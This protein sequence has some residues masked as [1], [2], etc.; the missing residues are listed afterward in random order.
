MITES[1]P[2]VPAL[3][4]EQLAAA[5]SGAPPTVT[6]DW[7]PP[8]LFDDSISLPQANPDELLPPNLAK[9]VKAVACATQTAPELGLAF[10]L[11]VLAACGQ[12]KFKVTPWDG[13]SEQLSQWALIAMPP[14]NRKTAVT[15][16]LIDPVLKWER[17]A[18]ISI[19]A[20]NARNEV[21]R[22]LVSGQIKAMEG[23]SKKREMN[24]QALVDEIMRMQSEVPTERPLQQVFVTDAT[25][26][27][28]QDQASEQNGR[29]A[30]LT[31][32]GF[33]FEIMAGAY[34]QTG[35]ANNDFFLRG[36]SGGPSRVRRMTR[37]CDLS[38]TA[39]SIGLAVQP[40]IVAD[41]GRGG[42]RKF[43]GTGLL[44]RFLYFF[45][46]S[47]V[48]SRD[49]SQRY[50][51][52]PDVAAQYE[53]SLFRL[54][55]LPLQIEDG[56]IIA[57]GLALSDPAIN[58][59]MEFAAEVEKDLGEGGMLA[60]IADWGG[61]LPGQ[62]LRI[63]GLLHLYDSTTTAI[64]D[65]VTMER[66]IKICRLAIPHA[67]HAFGMMSEDAAN[68]DAK[69]LLQWL[70]QHKPDITADGMKFRQYDAYRLRR[71]RNDKKERYLAA[72]SI[73]KDRQIVSSEVALPYGKSTAIFRYVN[74]LIY[75]GTPIDLFA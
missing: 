25:P 46:E 33:L 39:V 43:R 3:S 73:L 4:I 1:A 31:D 28:L 52:P 57:R 35:A 59:F 45:P 22:K 41:L 51:V 62:A 12:L 74:P 47:L 18:N 54:L 53:Q 8:T 72:L 66:A 68:S 11:S 64:I 19:A 44:A 70:L 48:G 63:A 55:E 27:A 71:F 17:E 23:A 9:M 26:E 40:A 32:E 61:K 30:V 2:A 7:E 34:S 14:G 58:S 75:Q 50:S 20:E 38:D 21:Q 15:N 37:R 36:H 6:L 69:F 49:V 42:K 60:G 10:A 29:A 56:K 67:L 24:N 65:H 16:T 5:A 13:Y